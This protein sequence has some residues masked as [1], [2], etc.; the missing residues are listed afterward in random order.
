MC[1]QRLQKTSF[2]HFYS[3]TDLS[4]VQT[5]LFN[6]FVGQVAFQV[7]AELTVNKFY[8]NRPG[9]DWSYQEIGDKHLG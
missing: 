4:D 9:M 5:L 3:L 2:S 1:F 6:V 7:D 8:W